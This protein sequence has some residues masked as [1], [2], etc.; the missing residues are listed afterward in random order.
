LAKVLEQWHHLIST[1]PHFDPSVWFVAEHIASGEIAGVSICRKRSWTD[2]NKGYL[3]SLSVRR[4]YRRNGLAMAL[5][6]HT[7]RAFWLRGT[8]TILLSVGADNL[9]GATH[10]YKKAGMQVTRHQMM[11]EKELRAGVEYSTIGID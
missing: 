8:N 11:Y 3:G 4:P 9:T 6:K 5:L 10:L 1:D 2:P 7:F